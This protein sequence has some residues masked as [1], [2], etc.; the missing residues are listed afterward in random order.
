MHDASPITRR[1]FGS[2]EPAAPKQELEDEGT[3]Q[4]SLRPPDP[5]FVTRARAGSGTIECDLFGE[6][7]GQAAAGGQAVVELD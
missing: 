7:D 1:S 3:D 5:Y 4:R 2:A 6:G